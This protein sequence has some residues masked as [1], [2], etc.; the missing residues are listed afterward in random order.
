MQ[1]SQTSE[2]EIVPSVRQH[3]WATSWVSRPHGPDWVLV[4]EEVLLGTTRLI[5]APIH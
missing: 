2:A 4:D 5:L 3:I 1:P